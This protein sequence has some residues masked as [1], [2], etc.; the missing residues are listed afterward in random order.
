MISLLHCNTAYPTPIENSNLGSILV[1]KKKFKRL[2]GYSD[3]TVGDFVTLLS[4]LNGAKIIEKHFS[5]NPEKKTFRDHQISFNKEQTDRFLNNINSI[6][7][8]NT[9]KKD[10]V[11]ISERKQNNFNIFRRS[12]YVVK[13]IKKNDI[14]DKNN[15]RCLRPLKGYALLIISR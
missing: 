11:T 14:L 3:H 1:L 9:K 6:K 8:V 10:L 4:Y 15:I 13:N 5:I 7:R 2:I 12:I